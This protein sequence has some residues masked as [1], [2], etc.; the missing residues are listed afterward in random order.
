MFRCNRKY[1]QVEYIHN[2]YFIRRQF[3]VN[4]RLSSSD[5]RLACNFK[6]LFCPLDDNFT[7]KNDDPESFLETLIYLERQEH[8]S[9]MC[10]TFRL[11]KT[12]DNYQQVV[13]DSVLL[14]HILVDHRHK[15]LYCYVPKVN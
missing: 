9:Q 5:L 2:A 14:D 4:L 13:N 11:L 3:N 7:G 1:T 12:D 10:Y 15:L 8:T 6:K